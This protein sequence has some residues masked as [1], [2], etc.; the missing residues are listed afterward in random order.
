[1]K[2]TQEYTP[3]TQEY[4]PVHTFCPEL[5]MYGTVLFGHVFKPVLLWNWCAN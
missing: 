3:Q 2:Q 1:M 4:T 5:K